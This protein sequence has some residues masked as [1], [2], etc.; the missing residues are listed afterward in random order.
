M[1]LILESLAAQ[2]QNTKTT[3]EAK[4]PN[5]MNPSR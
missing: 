4:P 2:P 3:E 1:T 5:V